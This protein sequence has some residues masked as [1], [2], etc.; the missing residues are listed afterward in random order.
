MT[1]LAGEKVDHGDARRP[2]P[3][4]PL[5]RLGSNGLPDAWLFTDAFTVSHASFPSHP[6]SRLRSMNTSKVDAV[7]MVHGTLPLFRNRPSLE[8]CEAIIEAGLQTFYEV[9]QALTYVRDNELYRAGYVTF[10]AYLKERW[11]FS[12]SWANRLMSGADVVKSLAATPTPPAS[13]AV[14]EELAPLPTGLRGQI[15]DQAVATTSR[16]TDGRPNPTAEEVHK[17]VS[18]KLAAGT[19]AAPFEREPRA[20]LHQDQAI[21]KRCGHGFRSFENYRLR[22]LLHAGGIR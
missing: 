16:V 2:V 1:R 9:G 15:W 3:I 6:L 5:P 12:F 8:S 14:A 4:P 20:L 22:V 13:V 17:L 10:Q 7:K 18:A 11:G 21:L 19:R